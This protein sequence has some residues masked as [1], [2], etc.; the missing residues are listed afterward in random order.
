[1]AI[2]IDPPRWPAHGTHFSHLVSDS[3]LAE[4]HAFATAAGILPRAFDH[5]HYDVAARR[6]DDLVSQGAVAVE[7]QELLRRLLSSGLRV[8]PPQRTPNAAMVLPVLQ[9]AWDGLLPGEPQLRDDLLVRW[10]EPH[11]AYHDVRHLAQVLQAASHLSSGRAP[12]PVRLAAW[13]HDAV[14]D[15]TAGVDER[16]SADLVLELLDATPVPAAEIEEVARLVLL[17]I[18]HDPEPGD[19]D[20]AVLADADLS[21]LGQTPGRYHVY[22]RDVMVEYGHLVPDDFRAGRLQVLESLAARDPLFRTPLGRAS[23]EAAARRNLAEE[24]QRWRPSEP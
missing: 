4:L 2:L 10:Q 18:D 7:P 8:R 19:R 23:W 14:H 13:F 5:D 1:M 3:S 11:R 16:A 15:G 21:V 6:Y 24:Q 22:V 9:A 20:G 12:R 17:T